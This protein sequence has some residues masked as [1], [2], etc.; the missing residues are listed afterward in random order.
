MSRTFIR[1]DTQ[2]RQSDLY[3]D[4]IVPSV[5]NYETNPANIEADLNSVRSQLQ[6]F[7]NRSG[8]T[9]PVG[10]WYDD[11]TAP[12]T[13]ENG[14][15]RGIN[16]ANQDLHDLEHKRILAD[17]LTDITVPVPA[18]AFATGTFT[19]TGAFSNGETVSIGGHVY[20][21]TSPFVNAAN[22]I[23]AS[24]TTAATHDNLRRA[25]NGAGVAGVNYGTGTPTNTQVTATAGATSNVLTAI[26]GG[27]VGNSIV[28]TSTTANASFASGTL[29]GGAGD[30]VILSLGQVPASPN[31]KAAI[32][33]VTTLGS[34]AAYVAAFGNNSLNLVTGGSAVSP[35]N[36]ATIYDNTTGQVI[37]SSGRQ[38]YALFQSE[39]NVDGSTITGTTPNRVQ[40]SFVRINGADTALEACPSADIA[41][42]TIDYINVIRKY[43]LGL[44]EQDFLRGTTAMVPTGTS[45]TRQIA[46][47]QQGVVPV[48]L[49]TNA[50]LDLNA[51]GEFWKIRDLVNADLFTITEGSTGG[52]TTVQLGVDVDT[53]RS[54]AIVNTF[55]KGLKAA[56]GTQEIDVGVTPGVIESTGAN[57]LR[58]LGALK[59][60]LDD[61][62]Q[63]GST[64]V[65][66]DGISLADSSPE[67]TAFKTAY[68][69]VSL[70]SAITTAKNTSSRN[71]KVY[72]VV[73]VTTNATLDVGGVGGG[74]NL[75]AQ[76]P[77]M[78][79]GTFLTDY[80]VFLNG[81]LLRPGATG[82]HDYYPG[83]SLVNGQLK[84]TF[85][86]KAG[87]TPDVLC[88]IPYA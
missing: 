47:D 75:D 88:V 28:T 69:E 24:G 31:N 34:V 33:S 25:I 57:N 70:L 19:S 79:T 59:L 61:S 68:G 4:T 35:K 45:V 60:K 40:L 44:D 16:Q 72:A 18:N 9:F 14:A 5:T 74:T 65:A 55:D 12:V 73:T 67:W 30:V 20:T 62:Y 38:V 52:T 2:I 84:F 78:S 71:P 81:T 86:V 54:N 15:A 77:N 32:G 27:T 49:T 85:K 82:T 3:D 10:K 17:N 46:Y 26:L 43:L 58:M 7:L 56:T 50:T 8:A 66:T 64:W 11:V 6:N 51:A 83:T 37:Q 13:F 48:E 53:F 80:D 42:K 1:Q 41:G 21:F 22:N 29:T 76:L 63:P 39:S 23:D 87:A 36:L